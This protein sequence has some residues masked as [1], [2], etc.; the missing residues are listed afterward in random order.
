MSDTIQNNNSTPNQDLV[1]AVAKLTASTDAFH[2][3]T[4]EKFA[5]I[6]ADI[7]EIKDGVKTAIADHELR[8]NRL[9]TS[10]GNH[11]ILISIGIGLL[12]LLTSILVYHIEK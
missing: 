3:T 4:N 12:T 2:T 6:K 8:I 5:D 11:A 10:R 7:K 1:I 9:E